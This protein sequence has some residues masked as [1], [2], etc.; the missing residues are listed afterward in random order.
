MDK[1]AGSAPVPSGNGEVREDG[2]KLDCL[3]SPR[4][5]AIIGASENAKKL[6]GR[7]LFHLQQHGFK[8]ALWP[9]NPTRDMIAGLTCYPDVASLPEAPD[10][11][12]V[13]LSPEAAV[14]AFEALG[15]RGAG[16]CAVLS[17]GFAE[18][19]PEGAALEREMADIAQKYGILL[20]GPNGLGFINAFNDTAA[21][22]S[23]FAEG[24]ITTSSV[25]FVS[26]SGAFGTAIAGLAR[27]RGLGL[28]WFVNT[29]NEATLDAWDLLDAAVDDDRINVL[30]AYIENLG[31]GRKMVRVARRAAA[32]GKPLLI[33]KVG[34]SERGAE[35]AAAHTGALATPARLFSGGAARSAIITAADERDMLNAIETLVRAGQPAG[36]RLGIVT[37][38]GGAGVLMA[39]LAEKLEAPLADLLPATVSRLRKF[40]PPF[41]SVKNPVDV[42]AQFIAQPQ[43]LEQAVQALQEDP[44]VDCVIVWLQMMDDHGQNI[45]ASLARCRDAS[46]TPLLV[47][48]IAAS[49][50][51][52]AALQAEE[53]AT[54]DNGG[55]AVRAA[56]NLARRSEA[57]GPLLDAPLALPVVTVPQD[58]VLLNAENGAICLEGTGVTLATMEL[59]ISADEAEGLVASGGRFAFKIASSDIAHKSDIG[60]VILGVEGGV[61]AREAYATLIERAKSCC[62]HASIDGVS[63][64]E[65]A[66]D[67]LELVFGARHDA[68]FGPVVMLGYGGIL[69]ELLGGAEFALAPVGIGQARAMIDALPAQKLM[70]GARGS[71][72]VDRAALAARFAAFSEFVAANAGS[73]AE[74]D[75]NPVIVRGDSALAVDW[76]VSWSGPLP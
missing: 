60:G 37:M 13:A 25:A 42:T 73:V 36:R 2:N 29:G 8:G 75:L 14:K 47:S 9:V 49:P 55:D 38:S 59:A 72:P 21:T 64:Q 28:G 22:F 15:K 62:P 24:P 50:Q 16:A 54:F 11:G 53:L 1:V 76:L 26:Q 57:I 45:A 23:Q 56:V 52:R 69:V 18:T 32:S 71:I 40:V 7:I 34:N 3:L 63:V 41:G 35:A 61:G 30:A 67:G 43:I 27:E 58:P 66:P 44:G 74:I 48:W 19:G 33:T 10:L 65:M 39:D 31:D 51:T 68:A 20:L 4:S 12:I 5:I 46:D 17:S 70:D 6:S